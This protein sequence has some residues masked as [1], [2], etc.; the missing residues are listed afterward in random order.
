MREQT[1][2]E[3]RALG[4]DTL[5]IEVKWSEVAPSPAAKTEPAFD[6][7][8]PAAYPGF[9]PYDDLVQQGDREGLPDHDHAGARRPATGRR[10]AVAAATTRSNSTD[11]ANFAR[12]VGRRYSG[13]FG[14][15]PAVKYF[16]IW[17]EPNHIFFLKPRSAVAARLPAPGR[18]RPA[19]AARHGAPR[20]RRSSS[21]SWR[22]SARR[23]R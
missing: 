13:A 3:I 15:L 21:A 2:D 4:A 5:R 18:A 19:G 1:L 17:N 14:G 10:R 7:T 16:S 6:A 22:R 23:P 8:D 20:G 11:F 9:E 12:A